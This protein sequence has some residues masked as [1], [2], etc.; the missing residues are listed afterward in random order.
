MPAPIKAVLDNYLI[1][2]TAL[3]EDS[4]KDVP[5]RATA[6]A[7]A[8][9]GDTLKS[10]SPRVAVQAETLAK[11]KDL[12]A[13]RAAFKP[14]SRSLIQELAAN[15]VP[16]GHYYEVYCPMAQASWLQTDKVVKNPYMGKAMARCGRIK[17]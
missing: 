10:L 5:E 1:I 11:A 12:E 16:A 15:Q 6:M 9:R 3:A 13:A 4:L 2:Q 7:K 17:K 14:L 8:A